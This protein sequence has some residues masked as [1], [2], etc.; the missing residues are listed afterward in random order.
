MI[1]RIN[2]ASN[3]GSPKTCEEAV[4]RK[5]ETKYGEVEFWTVELNSLE[6]LMS[7]TRKYKSIIIEDNG[8]DYPP[9]LVIYDD[10][11]E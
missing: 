6:E 10:Y 3:Y 1:Y 2:R 8:E 9:E 7:F 4:L 11:I 5:L